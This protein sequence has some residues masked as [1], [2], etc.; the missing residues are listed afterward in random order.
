M[1]KYVVIAFVLVTTSLAAQQL[2]VDESNAVIVFNFPDN[3]VDGAIEGFQFTGFIDLN[4]F[5]NSVFSGSVE[6]KTLDT[7]NWL[8]SRHLR[9]R[10]YFNAKDFPKLKFTSTSV[11]G[12]KEGFQVTGTL[13]IKGIERVVVWNFSND[14]KKLIGT[15]S[16]NTHDFDIFIYERKDRNEVNISIHLP[17][18]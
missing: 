6:T 18:Q 7:N 2:T 4:D 3:D 1:D 16:I 5:G 12:V 8:R 13:E 11:S 14:G 17:Y 15:T 9:A 10:K